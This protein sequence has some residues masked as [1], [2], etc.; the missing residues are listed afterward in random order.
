MKKNSLPMTFL[1]LIFLALVILF[2]KIQNNPLPE[3]QFKEKNGC[4]KE[5]ILILLKIAIPT[6]LLIIFTLKNKML[7]RVKKE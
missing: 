2:F 4:S 5:G 6:F 1:A 3:L 7:T